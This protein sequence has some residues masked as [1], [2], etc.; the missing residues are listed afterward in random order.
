MTVAP[1]TERIK[2]LKDNILKF[3]NYEGVFDK[4][5]NTL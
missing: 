3:L 5:K 4:N 1:N 2:E